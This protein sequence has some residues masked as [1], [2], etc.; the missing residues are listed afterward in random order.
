MLSRPHRL[1]KAADIAQTLSKG[2]LFRVP[3][4]SASLWITSGQQ[5]PRLGL[6]VGKAVGNSVIRSRVSRCIRHGFAPLTELLPAGSQLVVRAFA[7]ADRLTSVDWTRHLATALRQAG[8]VDNTVDV[9]IMRGTTAPA[10]GSASGQLTEPPATSS[11]HDQTQ[12]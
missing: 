7:G 12:Q 8:V 3:H 9:L 11:S 10:R 1:T 6:A 5:P 4:A 2:R